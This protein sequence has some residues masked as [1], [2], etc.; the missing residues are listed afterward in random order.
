[1]HEIFGTWA[2]ELIAYS[3]QNPLRVV[4]ALLGA[5]SIVLTLVFGRPSLSGDG[6]DFSGFYLGDGDSGGG[7]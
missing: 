5:T 6:N 7:D 1:V 3:Q 2:P 4:A